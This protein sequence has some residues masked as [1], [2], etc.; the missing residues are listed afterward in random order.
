M[1]EAPPM[2]FTW[3]G[4][5][6][7][8]L[9]PRLADEHFVIGQRYTLTEFH[10]RSAAS[11]NHYFAAVHDGW[12]NL[13]EHMA[14]QFPTPEHLRKFALIKAGY[15]DSQSVVCASRA[16]ALRVAAFVRG[17]DEFSVVTVSESTVTRWTAKSQSMRAMGKK[18][19]QESK[20]AVLDVIAAMISVAPRQLARE[21]GR[22]A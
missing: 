9:R 20:T 12:Q 13:P 22:A 21:A 3:D 10:Q 16:E 19:F 1:S 15:A 7:V 17:A 14:D 4:E 6:M 11:H 18:V 2:V 8:P 5:H